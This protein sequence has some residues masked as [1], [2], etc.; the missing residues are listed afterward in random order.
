MGFYDNVPGVMNGRYVRKCPTCKGRYIPGPNDLCAHLCPACKRE[1]N[2][3]T[4]RSPLDDAIK[5]HERSIKHDS[6]TNDQRN[7]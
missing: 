5:E 6:A 7:T 4:W 1:P 3:L 2:K